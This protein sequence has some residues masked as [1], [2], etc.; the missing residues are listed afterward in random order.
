LTPKWNPATTTGR[1]FRVMLDPMSPMMS[2]TSL[3]RW[4]ALGAVVTTVACSD[5]DDT[6]T[7]PIDGGTGDDA[8]DAS[9]DAGIEDTG[10]DVADVPDEE[11]STVAPDAEGS[12]DAEV[13]T[14]ADAGLVRTPCEEN[15]ECPEGDACVNGFCADGTCA[16]SSDWVACYDYFNALEADSG[17]FAACVSGVCQV[18]C[19]TDM[20]CAE[21]EICTDFGLC[22]PFEDNISA[23]PRAGTGTLAPV[24]VGFG[25]SLWNFPVGVP[26]GGYGERAAAEDGQYALGLRASIGQMH[27]IY[28][29]SA[30][31]D[32]G[33]NPLMLIR[34]PTIFTGMELHEEVALILQEET[35]QDWRDQ[36]LISSTHTHSGPCRHWHLPSDAALLL[37]SFGIGEFHQQFADW[38]AESVAE[39]ALDAL[40]NREPARV[41]YQIVEG[42]DNFDAI[43]RDRWNTTP[44]FDDNRL[45]LI[46]VEDLEG[47]VRGVI[48]S[49]AAHGTT[50][51]SN[52]LSGD[53]LEGAERMLQYELGEQ[54]GR[55][56][57]T[58]FMNQNSGSMSPAGDFSGHGF[59]QDVEPFGGRFADVAL[60][61]LEEMAT[62]T[63][64][65]IESNTF[66]FPITYDLLGYERGELSGP[67]SPPLGGEYRYGGISCVGDSGGDR[68]F[69]TYDTPEEINC[70]GAL[71]F[72][73]FNRPATPFMRSQMST[74]TL[75]MDD[76]D[77]LTVV[78]IP[79]ELAMELSWQILQKL[80]EEFDI[81]PLNSWTLGYTNS[82]LLYVLPTNMRGER[83]PF[84]GLDLPHPDNTGDGPDGLPLL[85]GK[86]DD[87]PD[88]SFSSLQGGYEAT[89]NPWG[90][91]IGDYIIARAADAVRQMRDPAATTGVPEAL[92]SRMSPR[93][94]GTFTTDDTPASAIA[95]TADAPDTVARYQ[96]IEV[97]WIGGHPGAEQ[98]QLPV[99]TLE[100]FVGSEGSGGTWQAITLP[101]TRDYTNM[102]GQMMTRLRRNDAG[103]EWVVRWEENHDFAA[104]DYRLRINGH[105]QQAGERVPYELISNEF[106]LL[107]LTNMVIE[108]TYD[109]NTF[110]GRVGYPAAT[111][112]RFLDRRADPGQV[113]GN[114][115]TRHP[116]TP[117]GQINP[118]DIEADLSESSVTAQ[119][120]DAAGAPVQ[121]GLI[122][123]SVT[124]VD[125]GV[126]PR[127]RPQTSLSFDWTTVPNGSTGIRVDVTDLHGNT[128]T[129]TFPLPL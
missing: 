98:P 27:G 118:A 53:V 127:R 107:P 38:I 57:P 102:E 54:T 6:T 21:G 15:A 37:G 51:G 117:T 125:L 50:N 71:Q 73:V 84:P 30:V 23:T 74:F 7:P 77:P 75:G 40:A 81:N 122:A 87:Y 62:T 101:N 92:P 119:F 120:V 88:F 79:G 89:M 33:E 126:A 9:G 128:G 56:I 31:I 86:P 20:E 36:L 29:R 39:A 80:E 16:D 111:S 106:E 52:Y 115:R 67:G 5:S 105:R 42:Y 82:H 85:P 83:P 116:W 55:Y 113:E 22:L 95:F 65:T 70:V 78:T 48:F 12:A 13:G 110:A 49:F 69:T 108:G 114:Y 41:G 47:E 2:T 61:V 93:D 109:G 97:S 44:Q 24:Q 4:L 35:G 1:L 129:A 103:T 63:D 91:R 68:D 46:K 32:N 124:M 100:R 45:L 64:I 90:Y 14:D 11:A 10:L 99:V 59:P 72:L 112:M 60:P 43:G 26:A 3:L 25:E 8:T 104:G 34:I 94:M 17:R 123:V 66:R 28:I 18:M 121:D 96:T 58:I 76:S 19:T